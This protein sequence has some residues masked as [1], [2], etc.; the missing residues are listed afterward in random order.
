[1]TLQEA[2]KRLTDSGAELYCKICTVDDINKDARTI[3][4]SPLDESAPILGVN[5]QANQDETD[6]F[7]AFPK[8]GAHVVVAF[9]SDATAVAVVFGAVESVIWTIG[10]DKPV[11]ITAE[12]SNLKI[13]IGDTTIEA[14]D[15][16]QIKFNGGENDGLVI[17][18]NLTDKINELVDAFNNHTHLLASGAVAVAGSPAAQSNPAPI[19][20][21]AI[22]SKATKLNKSDYENTKIKH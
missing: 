8:K 3:D 12:K 19:N 15:Q 13:S 6:G 18:K 7:V 5:L 4:V 16:K 21:P 11:E 2:L 20:I 10:E 17:I 1:M 9:L 22:T 14:D